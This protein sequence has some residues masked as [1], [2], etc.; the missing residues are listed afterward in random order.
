MMNENKSIAQNQLPARD[1]NSKS[2]P[3]HVVDRLRDWGENLWPASFQWLHLDLS[4]TRRL[5]Q[6]AHSRNLAKKSHVET[7]ISLKSPD[8]N[9]L[10]S[11][12]LH[13]PSAWK[14]GPQIIGKEACLERKKTA[15][16][17]CFYKTTVEIIT[18]D[19]T[20]NSRQLSL[21]ANKQVISLL[22]SGASEMN[23]YFHD[24][25]C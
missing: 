4:A 13:T 14:T 17:P 19:I 11:N 24:S 20:G 9:E 16:S 10:Q 1:N 8:Y 3:E 6:S 2:R 21:K 25:S 23:K 15:C 12:Q 7:K 22:L 18:F 5:F